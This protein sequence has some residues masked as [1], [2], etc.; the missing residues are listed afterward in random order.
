M[1]I[2]SRAH[3]GKVAVTAAPPAGMTTG[4][5]LLEFPG[6]FPQV[7]V[8]GLAVSNTEA[9]TSYDATH[10]AGQL[11]PAGELVTVP[12]P[13]TPTLNVATVP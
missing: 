13:T 10:T 1:Q 8:T 2:C 7:T 5:V 3:C 6:Q 11:I 12:V 4:Q 9:P